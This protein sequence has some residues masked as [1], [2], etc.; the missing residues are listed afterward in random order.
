MYVVDPEYKK[1]KDTRFSKHC[2][3]LLVA[4]VLIAVIAGGTIG[5]LEAIQF[6]G[7]SGR[8]LRTV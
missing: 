1:T 8:Y 6:W 5:V 2:C 3:W 7:S 4:V